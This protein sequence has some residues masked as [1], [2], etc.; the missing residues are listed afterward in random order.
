MVMGPLV[1]VAYV[2]GLPY[3]PRGVALAYSV[4]LAAWALPHIAWCVHGT[5]VPL[6][7]VM[8]TVS[9]P[10]LSGIVAA[11]VGLAFQATRPAALSPVAT[12]AAGGVLV[13]GAYV[14]MLLYAAG[15]KAFFLELRRGLRGGASTTEVS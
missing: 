2:L 11:A 10:L 13:T 12:L 3:G 8:R 4:A 9:K 14:W 7:D 15:Q 6:G 5:P 1:I